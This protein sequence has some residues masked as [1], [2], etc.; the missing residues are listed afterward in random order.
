M[1]MAWTLHPGMFMKMR[2]RVKCK[3][4]YQYLGLREGWGTPKANERTGPVRDGPV[5][6]LG[7]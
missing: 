6:E 2:P 7:R 5:I 3:N 4:A 1:D